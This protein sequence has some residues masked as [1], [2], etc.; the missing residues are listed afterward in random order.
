VKPVLDKYNEYTTVR[1]FVEKSSEIQKTNVKIKNAQAAHTQ[2]S[3]YKKGTE[4]LTKIANG[5]NNFNTDSLKNQFEDIKHLY[6]TFAYTKASL[7]IASFLKQVDAVNRTCDEVTQTLKSMTDSKKQSQPA[8]DKAVSR[9]EKNKSIIKE[10]GGDLKAIQ[11]GIDKVGKTL[12]NA[13]DYDNW[14]N[15]LSEVEW[16]CAL[17]EGPI[18]KR[19]AE[20]EK[21][22]QRIAA[23]AAAAAAVAAEEDRRRRRREE[24]EESSRRSH[25]SDSG[26]GGFGGFGGGSSGGGGTGGDY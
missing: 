21:E 9:F 16:L 26:G 8:Y 19:E 25:D 3:N 6:Q 11:S 2:L 15:I 24:E 13:Q 23:I 18:S 1:E 22:R 20:L 5:V 7:S 10:Y 4:S 12:S 14:I 17:I